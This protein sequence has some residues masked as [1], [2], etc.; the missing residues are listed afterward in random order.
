MKA[1]VTVK[2]ADGTFYDDYSINTSTNRGISTQLV[3]FSSMCVSS[4]ADDIYDG[5]DISITKDSGDEYFNFGECWVD[6][7]PGTVSDPVCDT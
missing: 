7:S 1:D 6:G 5:I 4:E 2:V 3:S